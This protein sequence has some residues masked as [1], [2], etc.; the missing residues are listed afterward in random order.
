VN[1]IRRALAEGRPALGMWCSVPT[2]L[3]A[4]LLAREGFPWL[5]IDLQHGAPDWHDLLALIQATELGGARAVVR[6][7]WNDPALIMRAA[8]L[9]A[10]AV[11][12]PMVGTAEQ[13]AAAAAALRYPPEGVRSFGPTRAGR[14]LAEA[15]EDIVCLVMVETQEGLDNLEEIAGA[16]GVDGIFLGPVDLSISLGLGMP[17]G[18]RN[19]QIDAA[20]DRCVEVTARHGGIVGT[21][22]FSGD[23]ARELVERGVRFVSVGNDKAYLRERAAADVAVIRA[24]SGG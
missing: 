13:A 14:P 18:G 11:I 5:A 19:E 3:T 2:P 17:P 22:S 10:I 7:G 1:P 24:L 8:D 4:E 15:N 16:P 12:V 23:H 6:V 9:G 21:I 20:L